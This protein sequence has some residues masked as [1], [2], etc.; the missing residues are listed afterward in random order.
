VPRDDWR[1]LPIG[2]EQRKERRDGSEGKKVNNTFFIINI[3]FILQERQM[4]GINA[5]T[6]NATMNEPRTFVQ[7]PTP[8][9]D[10]VLVK[11]RRKGERCKKLSTKKL[12]EKN[13][14]IYHYRMQLTKQNETTKPEKELDAQNYTQLRLDNGT[15]YKLENTGK[16]RKRPVYKKGEKEPPSDDDSDDSSEEDSEE[17]YRGPVNFGQI[18]SEDHTI[19]FGKLEDLCFSAWHKK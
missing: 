14:C 13:Y 9:C 18:W 12:G 7:P 4:Q 16:K 6:P 8:Q 10:Y 2:I 11:S 3:Q 15:D 17:E 1:N 5:P 19:D